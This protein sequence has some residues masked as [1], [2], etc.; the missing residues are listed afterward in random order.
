MALKE[1]YIDK[2]IEPNNMRKEI[3]D[4]LNMLK[5]KKDLKKIPKKHGNIP[6]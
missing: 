1:G 3:F 5:N 6:L 4:A 2:E